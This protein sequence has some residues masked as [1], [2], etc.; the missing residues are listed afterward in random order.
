CAT[1]SEFPLYP[2]Y[3]PST[4]MTSLYMDSK[5]LAV[6]QASR[7]QVN[8]ISATNQVVVL[9]FTRGHNSPH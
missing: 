1:L 5:W 4:P 7:L 9:V 8:V 6:V 2:N 3:S